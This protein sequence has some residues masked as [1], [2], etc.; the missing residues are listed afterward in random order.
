M[1][2]RAERER[3]VHC[4]NGTTAFT[5]AASGLVLRKRIR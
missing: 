1:N 5:D 2:V 3:E 4:Y